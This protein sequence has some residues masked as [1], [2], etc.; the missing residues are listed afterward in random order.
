MCLGRLKSSQPNGFLLAHV[1]KQWNLT[2][3]LLSV[4]AYCHRGCL[5][6]TS[7][8]TIAHSG[9]STILCC[10]MGCCDIFAR[11]PKVFIHCIVVNVQLNSKTGWQAVWKESVFRSSTLVIPQF[12]MWTLHVTNCSFN[13]WNLW[14]IILKMEQRGF[15]WREDKMIL[16]NKWCTC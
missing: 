9:H 5:T 10:K 12:N 1:C 11:F 4:F 7:T 6:S 2:V 15:K 14:K 16:F 13:L 8:F 3:A